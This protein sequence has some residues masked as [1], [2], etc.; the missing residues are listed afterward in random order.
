MFRIQPFHVFLHW[1]ALHCDEDGSDAPPHNGFSHQ[2]SECH[3]FESTP[4]SPQALLQPGYP[5][6]PCAGLLLIR[7][8]AEGSPEVGS[9]QES[10]ETECS[11]RS[12]TGCSPRSLGEPHNN[13]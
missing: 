1:I 6:L 11:S 7:A 3:A 9:S 8:A 12:R 5:A 10:G 2:I 13:Y 4:P